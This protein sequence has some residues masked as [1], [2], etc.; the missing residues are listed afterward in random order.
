MEDIQKA[1]VLADCTLREALERMNHLAM[2]IVLVVDERRCLV[3]T[4]TDGDVRRAIMSGVDLGSHVGAL[5][6]RRSDE[7]FPAKPI[8]GTR[9]TSRH[10]LVQLFKSGVLRHVPIV[11][12]AGHVVDLAVSTDFIADP[13]DAVSAV[14]MAGGRGSRLAPLTDAMPK[15]MLPVGGKPMMERLVEQL[16]EAGIRRV[17]VALHYKPEAITEH[18]GSGD[19]FGVDITY[20]TEDAPLGTAGALGLLPPQTDRLLVMN[21]DVMT[22]TNL[23]SLVTFHNEHDAVMTVGVTQCELSV[24]WG[25]VDT[26]GVQ[27]RGIVEKPRTTMFVNGGIYLLEPAVLQ[28]IDRGERLD[29]TELVQRLIARD[30]RVVAFP[31]SEYWL[32][33]GRPDDYARACNEVGNPVG[34]VR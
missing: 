27:I 13:I 21:G 29:M 33:M 6:A 19:R 22:R 16:R 31:I 9:D 11:D 34:G 28:H 18:F 24:P 5:L 7:R 26:D 23:R 30:Q 14:V 4:V 15:P 10:D 2:G 20:V 8:V 32:D 12:A 3:D 25:V 1:C 17:N